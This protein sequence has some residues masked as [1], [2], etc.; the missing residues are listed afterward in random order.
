MCADTKG[1]Y[2]MLE[3][4]L[5]RM[6]RDEAWIRITRS[7]PQ[8]PVLSQ[9][10]K[11]DLNR[12]NIVYYIIIIVHFKSLLNIVFVFFCF[13]IFVFAKIAQLLLSICNLLANRT[14]NWL[15][16]IVFR[17]TRKFDEK[18]INCNWKK[19]KKKHVCQMCETLRSKI[20]SPFPSIVKRNT[21]SSFL[22]H[23]LDDLFLYY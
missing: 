7:H 16:I 17:T 5:P 20:L 22:F 6:R 18:Y 14:K 15:I 19:T 1:N 3:T 12:T 13:A 21:I 2:D 8:S 23:L 11:M 9:R 4:E 10:V